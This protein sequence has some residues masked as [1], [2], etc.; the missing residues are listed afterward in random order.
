MWIRPRTKHV[1]SQRAFNKL[2]VIFKG[3]VPVTENR[4]VNRERLRFYSRWASQRSV[5][6]DSAPV[7]RADGYN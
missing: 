2:D 6:L 1:V 4:R 3:I 5:G 7:M